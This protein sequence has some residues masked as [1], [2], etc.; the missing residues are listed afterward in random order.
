MRPDRT[1][2]PYSLHGACPPEGGE[3]KWSANVWFHADT[4]LGS[5]AGRETDPRDE[6]LRTRLG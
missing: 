5:G 6:R 3:E 2:D 1:L 4:P